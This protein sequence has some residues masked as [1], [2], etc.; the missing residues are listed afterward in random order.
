H[1]DVGPR[2]VLDRLVAGAEGLDAELGVARREILLVAGPRRLRMGQEDEEVHLADVL[3]FFGVL[4]ARFGERQQ[5]FARQQNAVLLAPGAHAEP[6]DASAL[7]VQKEL[8]AGQQ[9]GHFE[10]D[11]H[12]STLRHTVTP[13]SSDREHHAQTSISMISSGNWWMRSPGPLPPM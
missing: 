10:L 2:R 7:R 8:M 4:G 3:Q 11:R 13:Q 1:D 6:A 5:A 9:L 12:G